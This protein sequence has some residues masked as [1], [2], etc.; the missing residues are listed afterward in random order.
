M[1]NRQS[2]IKHLEEMEVNEGFDVTYKDDNS[3]FTIGIRCCEM[4]DTDLIIAGGYGMP[5][6]LYE[7]ANYDEEYITDDIIEK[8][9]IK[10]FVK[11]EFNNK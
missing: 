7:C 1:L 6:E 9:G 8:F 2:L 5:V 3:E 10:E 11:I 4:M